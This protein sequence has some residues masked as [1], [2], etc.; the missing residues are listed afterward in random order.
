MVVETMVE[1]VVVGVMAATATAL[2][3]VSRHGDMHDMR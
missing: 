3:S 2:L 1:V